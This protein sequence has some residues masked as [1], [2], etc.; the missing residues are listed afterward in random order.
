MA[1]AWFTD[2]MF[3]LGGAAPTTFTSMNVGTSAAVGPYVPKFTGLLQKIRF[4]LSGQA[5]TSLAENA[6]VTFNCNQWVIQTHTFA[7][8]GFGLQ[9]AP[10][11]PIPVQDYPP[12][13][14]AYLGLPVN[15]AL[16]I[17]AQVQYAY[18]P[19]TPYLAI[20]GMFQISKGPNTAA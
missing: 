17:T 12:A 3:N 13:G 7:L 15:P 20:V 8:N 19:V 16:S 5:A 6:F 9:T 14:D 18:S 11:Q 2:V 1:Q 10:A 4:Y